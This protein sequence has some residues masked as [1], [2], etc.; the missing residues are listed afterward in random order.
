MYPFQAPALVR[1]VAFV[2][3]GSCPVETLPFC[4]LANIDIRVLRAS[5][6][7]QESSLWKA[8]WG[9]RRG[10]WIVESSESGKVRR[11]E[12][13]VKLI[14]ASCF[15]S[16]C[17]HR[18]IHWTPRVKEERLTA[19]PSCAVEVQHCELHKLSYRRRNRACMLGWDVGQCGNTC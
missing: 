9:V 14:P 2:A 6:I 13:I 10:Q 15:G 1:E 17:L 11:L 8:K 18:V 5:R 4:C 3:W 16:P 12:S 19:E 7:L